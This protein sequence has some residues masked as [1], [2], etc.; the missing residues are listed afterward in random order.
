MNIRFLHGIRRTIF[1]YDLFISYS[2]TDSL[3][4]AYAMAQHFMQKGFECFI[5]QLSSAS[6]G[7]SLPQKIGKAISDATAFVLIG[8]EAAARSGIVDQ[9]IR[10]FQ[11]NNNNNKPLIPVT[12][13]GAINDSA[14]W[15]EQIAGLPLIDDTAAALKAGKP[16]G[17]VLDRI[18][19][20]LEFTRKRT[21][22]RNIAF[23]FLIAV[24]GLAGYLIWMSYKARQATMDRDQALNE[25]RM[26]EGQK[27]DA[28]RSKEETDSLR[29]KADSLRLIAIKEKDIAN[30]K[31]DLAFKQALAAENRAAGLNMRSKMLYNRTVVMKELKEDPQ[32]AYSIAHHTIKHYPAGFDRRLIL[33]AVSKIDL[34]NTSRIQGYEIADIRDP[35]VLL[36]KPAPKIPEDLFFVF[37]IANLKITAT[38]LHGAKGWIMPTPGGWNI[39]MQRCEEGRPFYQLWSDKG[40]A[41]GNKVRG[42]L[43]REVEFIDN[44]R[45]SFHPSDTSGL[46]VWDLVSGKREL[47]KEAQTA[48]GLSSFD[49]Y[50]RLAGRPDG[51]WGNA[52][53]GWGLDFVSP[54]GDGLILTDADSKPDNQSFTAVGSISSLKHV[55]ARWSNDGKFLAVYDLDDEQLGLWE[56]ANRNFIWLKAEKWRAN[57][58]AWS[59]D[60]HL[61]ALA[62]RTENNADFRVEIVDVNSPDRSRKSIFKGSSPINDIIFLSE[63]RNIGISDMNGMIYILD[64]PSGKVI[65]KGYHPGVAK[66]YSTRAALCSRSEWNEFRVWSTRPAP[67]TNW[68]FRSGHDRT[69]RANGA[70]DPRWRWLAVPYSSGKNKGGIEIRNIASGGSFDLSVADINS[71]NIEFSSDGKWLILETYEHLRIWRTEDWS[72][73]DFGLMSTD[74]QF[75]NLRLEGDTVVAHTLGGAEYDYCILL[76]SSIPQFAG[77]VRGSKERGDRYRISGYFGSFLGGWDMGEMYVYRTEGLSETPGC[78][79]VTR[80][81]CR[82]KPVGPCDCDV[83]FIPDDVEKLMTIYDSLLWKPSNAD[84]RMLGAMD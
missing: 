69:Y 45:I 33:E 12:I 26:A 74:R 15:Y 6:P 13:D 35:Y 25:K 51:V 79:W 83:E 9:E 56:P 42:W 58:Y 8:S 30:V 68:S 71:I 37:D 57:A 66:L 3:D 53:H 46:L 39:L 21:R 63:D 59:P 62:G 76:K 78:G 11:D 43:E 49:E 82:D 75:W 28:I 80:V 27:N 65:G 70:A 24:I 17:D 40:L 32:A 18:A 7:A 81:K 5:D 23:C 50:H 72:Y 19:N 64:V 48:K 52:F 20:A 44:H 29:L 77:R 73:T 14:R 10:I 84:L 2:R 31:R 55:D 47:I 61:L 16:A 34:Y 38:P 67:L 4:Y 54:K 1:G 22:L 41:V 36:S 60:S